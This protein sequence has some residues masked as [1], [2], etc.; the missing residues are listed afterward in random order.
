[1]RT[2]LKHVAGFLFSGASVYL[3]WV[4]V[5]GV[6]WAGVF[7][8]RE[9]VFVASCQCIAQVMIL[10]F[11]WIKPGSMFDGP[12][13]SFVLFLCSWGILVCGIALGIGKVKANRKHP[14]SR[15]R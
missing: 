9:N 11:Q 7:G 15:A 2:P 6:G 5:S 3:F 8:K 10:P 13:V 1:M 4:L 14:V 12:Y